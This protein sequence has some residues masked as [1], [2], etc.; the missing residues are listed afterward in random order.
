M[1]ALSIL[2]RG[3]AAGTIAAAVCCSALPASAGSSTNTLTVTATVIGDCVISAATLAFGNYDPTVTTALNGST[4]LTVICT[5]GVGT[6]IAMGAGSNA[7]SGQRAMADTTTGDTTLQYNL[8]QPATG[9]ANA[10]CAYTTALGDGTAATLSAA[11]LTITAAPSITARTYNVCGQIPAKQNVA[12]N[13]TY[14]D[15]VVETINF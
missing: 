10:A 14:T 11:A 7:V 8:F 3:L 5:K 6:S 15:S 1:F 4:S 9:A 2:R 13:T 12:V